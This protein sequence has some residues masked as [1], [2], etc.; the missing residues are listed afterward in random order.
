M[1]LTADQREVISV[2]CKQLF[3]GFESRAST[4]HTREDNVLVFKDLAKIIENVQKALE[5]RRKHR[6]NNATFSESD[7]ATIFTTWAHDSFANQLRPDQKTKLERQKSSI[8][9]AWVRNTF[10]SKALLRA[11]LQNGFNITPSGAPENARNFQSKEARATQCLEEVL[12]W[13]AKFA[14][15]YS[16]RK[17][18]PSSIQARQRSGT[19]KGESGLTNEQQQA[20]DRRNRA[21][22]NVH[23]ASK[24]KREVDAYWNRDYR[25]WQHPRHE[26]QMKQHER[27]ALADLRSGRLHQELREAKDAHGGPVQADP[28]RMSS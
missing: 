14:D 3:Y 15:D 18:K 7:V 12:S 17:S 2:A 8:F 13:L 20:R 5:H 4:E 27:R 6:E 28:F 16:D 22:Q 9:S 19:K 1:T 10:G 25:S 21:Q 11:S 26:K 23:W 24:L